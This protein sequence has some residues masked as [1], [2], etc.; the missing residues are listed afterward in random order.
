MTS[1]RSRADV[2]ALAG[3]VVIVAF[4]VALHWPGVHTGLLADD[5]LQRAMLDGTYPVRRAPW[6][7][8]AFFRNASEMPALTASGTLPW[9]MPEDLRLSL[10]RPLPS[11]LLWFDQRVLGL[12]PLGMHLHSLAWL[13]AFLFAFRELAHRLLPI[14]A[15]LLATALVASDVSLVSPVAWLCNRATL[16][17]ATFGALTLA[18]YHGHQERPSRGSAVRVVLFMC[19]ALFGG[20]YAILVLSFL[21][22]CE[23]LAESPAKVRVRRFALV[24]APA[25]VYAVVHVVG[26][27]GAAGG[28]VYLSPLEAPLA[29]LRGVLYRVPSML[30]TELLLLPGEA[31]YVALFLRSPL[32][33]WA[34]VPGVLAALFVWRALAG[35]PGPLP[36]RMAGYAL[37]T[38]LGLVPLAGTVPG[39]RLLLLPSLGGSLVLAAAFWATAR[40]FTNRDGPRRFGSYAL[41]LV[42][43]PL[44][45]LHLPLSAWASRDQSRAFAVSAAR[46]RAASYD[47][48]IDDARVAEQ[49]L[50]LLNLPGDLVA[51][52]YPVR[53]RHEH[54]SPRPKSYRTLTSALVP[55]RVLRVADDVLELR[56]AKPG[57]GLFGYDPKR[58][59]APPNR[60]RAGERRDVEGLSV[61]VMELE[62]WAPRRIR[63]RFPESLDD[64]GRV[65]LRFDH[66]RLRR[67]EIPKVGAEAELE[68]GFP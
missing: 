20:E 67:F 9:W 24:L 14:P 8:Y 45:V 57:D 66:G 38:V 11:L 33:V 39:V 54:G 15:A 47:S 59:D 4:A 36:K 37:G 23:V 46:L 42:G 18:A 64:P 53:V 22:G 34:V 26:R 10:L 6:D 1:G 31:V 19:L 30:A 27:Y 29:F 17:T 68:V 49:D 21:L 16:V 40:R 65:F 3:F 62:D 7:L 43:L 5:Y 12:S 58:P 48:E 35:A 2:A 55:I 13:V 60:F 56:V 44:F 32:L 52:D 25:V 41:L 51:I 63:Y 28:G 61:E 50:V